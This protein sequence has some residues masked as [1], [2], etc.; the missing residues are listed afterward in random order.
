MGTLDVETPD[1][2]CEVTIDDMK[3][4]IAESKRLMPDVGIQ[5]PP[6]LADWWGELVEAGATD[7][8]GLSANGDHISPEHPF[9]SPHQVRKGLAPRGYALT[10]RLCAY[11]RYLDP[12]WMAQSLLDVV[13]LKYWSFI[14]RRGSG[15]RQEQPPDPE[16]APRA[17]ERGR[18]GRELSEAELAALFAETRPAVIEEMRLA[19][20]ELRAE[21][22]GEVATFVVNRN[23]N[24]TNVCV[25]GCAFCGFGQGRRSPD[26]YHVTEDDFAERVREAV[27]FG[28]TEICMQGGIHPEYTLEDYGR[29]LRLAKETAPQLHLHAYSPM[30]VHYMCER[31][32]RSPEAVFEYL[33]EC[34]LGSTPG[35]AAEVLDDGVRQRISPNKLPVARWV[36]IIEASHRVG[37]RSTSTVMFG[38]IEEPRELARHMRVVRGLQERTGGI[39]EFVPLSFIPYNTLLGRTHG[40]EEISRSENLKHTAAFRLALGRSIPNLQASWVKMGLDAATESLRWGVN[41]LGG[42]LMEENISRMAGS[43]HGVRLEPEQLVD[44]ARRAGRIPAQRTTLYE[45]VQTH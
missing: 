35:T 7:L 19:A 33:V 42:T 14:P 28:A 34:G 24:F 5:I 32:G 27:E 22:A 38:H 45:I 9:P 16:I 15:R 11:P 13:K 4:L 2:A 3:R 43:Q 37:L 17:V 10:E 20:D 23:I 6:N 36:E 44:A 29:W 25:V 8:G 26:A 12:D 21:L 39:T 41:D 1:W 31:S 18:E 40:V 30:E